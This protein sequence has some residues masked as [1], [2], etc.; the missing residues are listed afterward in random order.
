VAIRSVVL[1]MCVAVGASLARPADAPAQSAAPVTIIFD[2]D[3]ESDVD[4]VGA[5][6][7]L[8][9]LARRGEAE[10][11]AM[12]ISAGNPHC[13][14]CLDALNTF[15]ARP[16]IPIGAVHG[17]AIR[18]DSLYAP[19]VSAEFPHDLASNDDAPEAS[20]VYRSVLAR[21]A[22]QSVVV[23]TVGFLTNLRALLQSQPDDACP[24][25]G[26]TLVERK[27][28]LWVCMGGAF[29]QGRE[30]NVH[31]DAEA[32]RAVIAH[33]PTPVVFSGFEIGN[34]IK[35]GPKLA[36]LPARDPVRRAYE[37]YNGLKPRESWDQTAVY[38]AVR[39]AVDGE[40]PLW[41][42]SPP[43][44]CVVAED[45]SNTWIDQVDGPH[46]Y[47]VAKEDPEHVA[48]VIESLMCDRVA[49]PAADYRVGVAR[50]DITPDYPIRLNGFGFRREESEGV[51]QRIWAKA[52]AVQAGEG[53]PVIV[54]S[55]DSLGIRETMVDEVVRRIGPKTGVTRDRIA[56]TF[57]HSHTTPK[58]NGASDTIFSTPIPAEHQTHIDRYTD[59]LTSALEQAAL[60]AVADLKP[61]RLEWGVG[62]VDFAKNRR[63]AGGPVDH[64]LPILVV[65]SDDGG[66]RAVYTSYACHCVTLSHNRI[67]GDWAGYAQE[68]IERKFPGAIGLV[69]IGC[70][71]DSNPSSGVVNDRV[72]IATEQGARIADEVARVV[73]KGLAPVQGAIAARLKH[74]DLPLRDPPSPDALRELAKQEGPA[75][76]NARYQLA[77]LERGEPLPTRIRYP[78][79]TI[80]FG[81]SL[82]MIFLA[83]EVCVDYSLRLKNELR[84]DRIW[85]H[86][87]C[88]DFCAYIP[89]ERL[90]KEGGYGGGAEVVYFALPEKFREG[91]E[92]TIIDTVR[93]L[94]P[95]EFV[96]PPGSQGV[97]P[98]TPG[99]S[100]RDFRLDPR[101]RIELVASEP[102]VADPVAIDFGP[103]GKLW[104]AEMPDYSRE[105]D[106]SFDGAG[107]VKM[108]EDTDEDG[109]YDRATVFL[110][111]LRFPTG[112]T[113]WRDG[114]LVC[115]AP[116]IVLARDTDGDGKADSTKTLYA[117]FATHNPHAR[118]NSLRFGLDGWVYGSG[119]LFGG[120][121]TSFDGTAVHLQR[122]D[123]RIRPDTG[124]IE[125]ATGTTQQSRV[126]DDWDNWFGCDNGTLAMHYPVSDHYVRRNPLVAPPSPAV[127]VA[128][129]AEASRLVPPGEL[130]LFQLSGKPGRATS[131][132]G[133]DVY[134]DRL[135]GDD[136]YGDCFTCEPVHQAV[137]R[138][139]LSRDGAVFRGTRS[140]DERDREFLASTDR[141]FRPVQVRTGPDGGL[142]IVDMYRYVIEHR[143][144]I[145]AETLA[146][147]DP[148]AGTTRGR[149]YR[150]VPKGSAARG[151]P[152]LDRLD[153]EELARCLD[154]ANGTLRDLA[155]Q[156]LVWRNAREA[157][158]VLR[159]IARESNRPESRVQALCALADL[160]LAD[161]SLLEDMLDDAHPGVRRHAVRIAESSAAHN[162]RIAAA[163][164]R[165]AEDAAYEVRLQTAYSLGACPDSVAGPM[166]A[167]LAR[168]HAADPYMLAAVKSSMNRSNAVGV[169][170]ALVSTGDGAAGDG[171]AGDGAAG[172]GAAGDGVAGD[173]VAG[174]GAD[175]RLLSPMMGL[176]V[177]LSG[178]KG[179]DEALAVVGERGERRG[180]RWRFRVASEL[181][182]AGGRS[183]SGDVADSTRALL[184]RWSDSARAVAADDT[185]DAAAR[186]D[187]IGLL[188]A[189][190]TEANREAAAALVHPAQP[191]NVRQAAVE[192]M[193]RF[194]GPDAADDLLDAWDSSGPEL[195]REILDRLMSRPEWARTLLA[196][197][198]SGRVATASLDA[199][200][201]QRLLTHE[202]DVVRV[203]AERA[204]KDSANAERRGIVERYSGARLGGDAERGRAAFEKLCAACHKLG[205]AGYAV[206]PDL[207]ALANKSPTYL[208]NALLDPNRDVEERYQS[209]VAVLSDGRTM[210]GLMTSETSASVTLTEQEGKTH[211][212]RRRDIESLRGSGRSLMPVGFEQ[213]VSVEQAGDLIAFLM[214]LGPRP[215]TLEGNAPS[216]V[217]A[218][219]DGGLELRAAAAE[220]Y[221]GSIAFESLF[222]NIGFWHGEQDRVSWRIDVTRP[223][224][225]DVWIDWA[226]H[227]DSAGNRFRID[228]LDPVIAGDVASTGGWDRYERRKVGRARLG[229]GRHAVTVRPEGA[230][231]NGALFD[232]RGVELIAVPSDSK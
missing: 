193:G 147:L 204:L 4:D 100:L 176:S 192:A 35:T 20:R 71:S 115:D 58:V 94:T 222:G 72:D 216:L 200:R 218:G 186:L 12:G 15:F 174:D 146:Q 116:N 188:G 83:G 22:D 191:V 43:G 75:A 114:I 185:A 141:W 129:D 214:E 198:E 93:S 230:L 117:G 60:A 95:A 70:G 99:E 110:D 61:G 65:R 87:Y 102:L 150:V 183:G 228:G 38:F 68:M 171:V 86:G 167:R 27:V 28:R 13:A 19:A 3:I 175:D 42:L 26:Q 145:P 5:V 159:N 122:S 190:R 47:L 128:A 85:P 29:P 184:E 148:M 90:L 45:G 18:N 105:V 80:T 127:A 205:D 189:W 123:F 224:E 225:Y 217:T 101:F 158:S 46:R 201:R 73:E 96:V 6:A 111:G 166:L 194:T 120:E 52:L 1:M 8:H 226:C 137:H 187:A 163:I 37:L 124:A 138:M 57:T 106:E 2:T 173:G 177:E 160:E 51:T 131:A 169:I 91:L 208:L 31:R 30:W 182:E 107:R 77:R 207:A 49:A 17:A 180:A 203:G 223:G 48:C 54:M 181:I 78:V 55:V 32:S 113:V 215:K 64:D 82:H 210:T 221:G 156:C 104:V 84:R 92:Q 21:Q 209:Y 162:E 10:I 88:N 140:L 143:R 69:S 14:P 119:G 196:A 199:A 133:I 229:A 62:R 103:D 211:V 155:H 76:Y 108:L 50:V 11:V 157:G 125:P 153:P 25:D 136:L 53:P 112:V 41:E 89:S 227:P 67:S 212:L 232:L 36:A 118:V 139:D 202:D 33:W 74:V 97:A 161:P 126:R 63:T 39:G 81:E 23:V 134:R 168:T 16:D 172:D 206:G 132:C 179:L 151:W 219:S 98:R 59:A 165:L 152:R 44:R 220:I 144:W 197:V 135:L 40:R 24:L 195:R 34:R 56:V 231:R 164:G 178:G 154:H 121:I 149:I 142:W 7:L 66:V 109:T 79:Q 170:R 9:A 130:V 213:D